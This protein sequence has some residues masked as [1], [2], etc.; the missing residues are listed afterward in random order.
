M[1]PKSI[2]PP[3]VMITGVYD[4][5]GRVESKMNPAKGEPPQMAIP[6]AA[7]I[8]PIIDAILRTWNI[9]VKKER[10]VLDKG[11]QRSGIACEYLSF[12][13]AHQRIQQQLRAQG[14][15]RRLNIRNVKSC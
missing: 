8:N 7:Y 10:E 11:D 14:T 12:L 3:A 2:E 1:A 4:K 6:P 5:L 9:G 13:L 15:H